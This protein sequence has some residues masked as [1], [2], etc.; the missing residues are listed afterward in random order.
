M[1]QRE[2][3]EEEARVKTRL[4]SE[5]MDA[6][7]EGTKRGGWVGRYVLSSWY[8]FPSCSCGFKQTC[9]YLVSRIKETRGDKLVNPWKMGRKHRAWFGGWSAHRAGEVGRGWGSGGW[10]DQWDGEEMKWSRCE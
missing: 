5:T 2:E 6:K 1:K 7:R 9:G 10:E 4:M 3:K 8:M